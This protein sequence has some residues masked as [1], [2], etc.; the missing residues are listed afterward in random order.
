MEGR[1]RIAGYFKGK[2][3]LIIGSTGF[4]GKILMEKILRVEPEVK[5]VFLLVRAAEDESAKQRVQT[6][7]IKKEIFNILKEEHGENFQNFMEEKI[8]PIAGDV[9]FKNL[10]IKCSQIENLYNEIDIIVNSAATTNFYERYDVSLDVNTLGAKHVLE[11]AKKCVNLKM[12]LHV[13]TAYVAGLQEGLIQEKPINIGATL[14]GHSNLDIESELRLVEET[15]RLVHS[16]ESVS[17]K[18]IDKVERTAMKELGIKRARYFGWPNT[19]VF[20]KAMGEMILGDMRGDLPLV[21]IRP[22]IITSLFKDPLPGWMEGTRTIDSFVVGYMKG[23][24]SC[25]LADLKEIMDVIPGD[26]VVNAM[27]AAIEAHSEENVEMIYHTSS[28]LSNP[29][30]FS[31]LEQSAYRYFREN[32]RIGTDGKIMP[33]T[34]VYLFN[35]L[36]SF[37]VYMTLGYKLPLKILHMV[38]LLS[39]GHFSHQYDELSRRYRYIMHLVDLYA[40]YGFFK[41]RFDDMNLQ[42]LRQSM[43]KDNPIEAEMF[44]FDP[45]S[46][47]WSD[48]FQETHIPGVVKYLAK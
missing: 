27:M 26:M 41:G 23:K 33:F 36:H 37:R 7:V 39:F 47:N 20:T 21:I 24:L 19:Y 25:Y 28:S 16:D 5:R 40:P 35:T 38:N 17:L 48:Y 22:T 30:P 43:A 6:E 2:S 29:V 13:S 44:N 9:I 31:T 45:K 4:L 12:L 14:N 18:S 1:S 11:F 3:I 34:K 8:I 10:G 46:I 32:P 15:K 42:R